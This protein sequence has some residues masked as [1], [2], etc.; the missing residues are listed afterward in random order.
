MKDNLAR[1]AS[2]A[3]TVRL[4]DQHADLLIKLLDTQRLNKRAKIILMYL[5]VFVRAPPGYDLNR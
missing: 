5:S 3:R 4:E 1:D 2:D